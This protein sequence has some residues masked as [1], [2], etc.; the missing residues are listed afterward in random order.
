M[1]AGFQVIGDHGGVQIDENF[2]NMVLIDKG[3]LDLPPANGVAN[4][5]WNTLTFYNRETPI[6][7]LDT[8]NDATTLM[9][10]DRSGST[11]TYYIRG[12][13][14][15]R[16][17]TQ[18]IRWYLFDKA[19]NVAT[20]TGLTVWDGGGRVTFNSDYEP[21]RIVGMLQ[22]PDGT[23]LS[24]GSDYYTSIQAAY[25]GQKLA[26]AISLPKSYITTSVFGTGNGLQ[27]MQY[28]QV[29]YNGHPFNKATVSAPTYQS[30][31][32]EVSSAMINSEQRVGGT[33]FAIDITNFYI[34]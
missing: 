22:Y 32:P 21:M 16:G 19:P 18:T 12:N 27:Y 25:V 34:A 11:F 4:D 26:G 17:F 29:N 31:R 9:R 15:T 2:V 13:G 20:N 33:L 6:L 10:C 30:T 24:G 23:P 28:L 8:R 5:G 14:D 1:A 3:S 7:A